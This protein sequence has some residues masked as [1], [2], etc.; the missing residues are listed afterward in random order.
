MFSS[1]GKRPVARK[2][3][4]AISPCCS[5]LICIAE[6]FAD[7]VECDDSPAL[8]LNGGIFQ[9]IGLECFQE[10]HESFIQGLR[11]VTV[12]RWE[13]NDINIILSS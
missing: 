13:V 2:P 4:A 12:V 9:F 10:P 7:L 6:L 1:Q 8:G 5:S 3:V 11:F